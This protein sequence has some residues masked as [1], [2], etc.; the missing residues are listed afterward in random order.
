MV[1]C[2]IHETAKDKKGKRR[3]VIM[4]DQT[5]DEKRYD[6][7]IVSKFKKSKNARSSSRHFSY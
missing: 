3:F 2:D 5:K 6:Q 7:A 4:R 1:E